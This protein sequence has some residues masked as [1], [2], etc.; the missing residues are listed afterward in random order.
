MLDEM[1]SIGRENLDEV[2]VSHYDRKEDAHGGAEVSFLLATGLTGDATVVEL[3][4]GI[5]E[6]GGDPPDL[7]YSRYALHHLPDFWKMFALQRIR[8]MLRPGGLFR[9]WDVVFH[10]SPDEIDER[11]ERWCATGST[12]EGGWTRADLEEHIRDEHSTFTWL[13]EPMIGYAGFEIRDVSYA[14]DGFTARY[15]LVAV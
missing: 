7:V 1:V 11:I 6:H 8:H 13:L 15:V 9:L 10:F 12:D 4:A 14:D 2:H 5:Y 3:G